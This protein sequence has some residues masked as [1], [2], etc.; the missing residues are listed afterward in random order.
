ML[1]IEVKYPVSDLDPIERKLRVWKAEI[2]E[3]QE[4]ADRYFNAPDRDFAKTDEAVRIRQIG[5][6]NLVTYKGPKTDAQTKTRTEIEVPLAM[7]EHIAE[8]FGLLL[9][10]LGYRP[11]A[12]VRKRRVQ[13]RLH[14]DGFDVTVCLDAVESVGK[15]VEIEIMAPSE[16]LGPAKAVLLKL[17]EELGL[18]AQE[19]RSYL[20]LLLMG[21][22]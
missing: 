15:F 11:V 10:H 9:I 2:D 1:E 13:C 12:I 8:E 16:S 17:A 20:E 22:K 7:G 4:E 3:S 6:A 21:R 19:R 18:Q 5:Q 14:R